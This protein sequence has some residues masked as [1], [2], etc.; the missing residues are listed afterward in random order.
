[1]VS[2]NIFEAMPIGL[3][4][5]GESSAKD[6]SSTGESGLPVFKA[7]GGDFLPP[8]IIDLLGVVVVIIGIGGGASS[9]RLFCVETLFGEGNGTLKFG[10]IGGE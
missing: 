2:G 9:T 5:E 6:E 4:T 3:N 7:A 1:M 8:L 10:V